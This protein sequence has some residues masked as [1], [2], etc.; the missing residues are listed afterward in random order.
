MLVE[1]P[2][3]DVDAL[4][5]LLREQYG[6]RAAPAFV[7]GAG[8]DSWCFDA[9]DWWASVRR[10]R[11]G[12]VPAA[13]AAA[14]ELRDR[15][16]DF[17]LAP[18][19]GRD[20]R[21][22]HAVGGAPVVVF[23]REPGR[24]LH[25]DAASAVQALQ[26]RDMIAALHAQSV[27]TE[28]PT[29]TFAMPFAHELAEGVARATAGAEDAGPY[30]ARV[31]ALVRANLEAI[32]ARRAE[33]AALQHLCRTDPGTLVLTHGEP[34]RG[35][36][37]LRPDGSLRLMD[38][39]ALQWGPPE[40]DLSSLPD[41]GFAPSGRAPFLRYYELLWTLGEVAEYVARFTSP[42]DGNAEDAEKW[43]ELLLYLQEP[44]G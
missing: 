9:C 11:L 20:G 42:H 13:Y 23:V 27:A 24:P 43:D 37:M 31:S 29:E 32:E 38:W 35:N 14:C 17:V 18:A 16:L 34:D 22:V 33:M 21:V 26:V 12:H 39:G 41:L 19:R 25:P 6:A 10:D 2:D 4:A 3:I 36:I 15:G 40:R 7:R 28:L 30:G 5:A 1:N 8:G 44:S